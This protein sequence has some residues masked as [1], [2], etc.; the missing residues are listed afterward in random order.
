MVSFS[1]HERFKRSIYGSKYG[2]G[3]LD[4]FVVRRE[5]L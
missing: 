4:Y 3:R 1:N 5:V 2:N